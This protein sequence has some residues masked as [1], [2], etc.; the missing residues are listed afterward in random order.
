MESM[1]RIGNDKECPFCKRH[2]YPSEVR[3]LFLNQT[4]PNMLSTSEKQLLD[5]ATLQSR[6][7]SQKSMN[8]ALLTRRRDELRELHGL[9]QQVRELLEK[10]KETESKKNQ[11]SIKYENLKMEHRVSARDRENLKKQVQEVKDYELARR[12]MEGHKKGLDDLIGGCTSEDESRSRRLAVVLLTVRE[13]YQKEL[14]R[15]EGL[16]RECSRLRFDLQ[17]RDESLIQLKKENAGLQ[18]TVSELVTKGAKERQDENAPSS[19]FPPKPS[20]E[21]KRMKS[22]AFE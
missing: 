12:W 9:R 6:I 2:I 4:D 5:N 13:N 1:H 7:E 16:S 11:L 17:R 22:T 18:K 20:S 14:Q 10:L 3:R 21:R 19:L 15:S 8:S